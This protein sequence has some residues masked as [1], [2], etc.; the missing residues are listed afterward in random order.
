MQYQNYNGETKKMILSINGSIC[1]EEESCDYGNE[2]IENNQCVCKF[3]KMYDYFG[4]FKTM[5]YLP[6]YMWH[7]DPQCRDNYEK[8]YYYQAEE[9]LCR[10][11]YYLN[12]E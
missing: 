2:I 4:L 3:N 11:G 8:T 1:I 7:D 5:P 6:Y 12:F 10:P 9:L